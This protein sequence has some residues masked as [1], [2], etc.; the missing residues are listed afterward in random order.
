MADPFDPKDPFGYNRQINEFMHGRAAEPKVDW[1]AFLA[2]LNKQ[3][4][5]HAGIVRTARVVQEVQQVQKALPERI[6]RS[7]AISQAEFFLAG[8]VLAGHLSSLK[9]KLANFEQIQHYDTSPNPDKI[10]GNIIGSLQDLSKQAAEIRRSLEQ[11]IDTNIGT[12]GD[13][14][15]LLT[16]RTHAISSAMARIKEPHQQPRFAGLAQVFY[17][18]E[19]WVLLTKL[20]ESAKEL[21]RSAGD[22]YQFNLQ[23]TV[24]YW[25]GKYS[26]ERAKSL[27]RRHH[28]MNLY[29]ATDA[30]GQL[31][32]DHYTRVYG[33]MKHFP[34]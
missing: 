32:L 1:A 25:I 15:K 21:D 10:Y 8:G 31:I 26:G 22:T 7:E 2:N 16:S 17:W 30:G 23:G 24:F 11:L 4:Q 28:L 6:A 27:V 34:I 13:V 9:T 3:M 18:C 5:M 14:R 12:I 33:P 29:Q 20:S 19:A